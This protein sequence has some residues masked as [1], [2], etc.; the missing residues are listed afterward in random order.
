MLVI[1]LGKAGDRFRSSL[2]RRSAG[3]LVGIYQ[4]GAGND[5]MRLGSERIAL[6]D[7]G[8]GRDLVVGGPLKDAINGGPGKDRLEGGLGND[9]IDALDGVSD[10]VLCGPDRDR[11]RVDPKDRVRGCERVVRHRRGRVLSQ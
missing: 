4:A 8:P 7:A 3:K 11:A 5:V 9:G 2:D 1:T 6:A 10:L